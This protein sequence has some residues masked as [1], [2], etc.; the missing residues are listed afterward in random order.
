[1]K[2]VLFQIRTR[3]DIDEVAYASEFEEMLRLVAD[4]PG[5]LGI[6]GFTGEDGSELAVARFDSDEAIDEWREH[7][8]HSATR[9][10]GRKEFFESY[11]ITIATV[12]RHYDWHR[13]EPKAGGPLTPQVEVTP[14]HEL[15]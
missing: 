6:D 11:D 15:G 9:E 7:P 5:F 4:V 8:G 1:M 10:R 14:T 2:V 13:A 12:S 3:D